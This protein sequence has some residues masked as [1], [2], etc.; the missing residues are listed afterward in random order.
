VRK[1][2][3]SKK[4]RTLTKEQA[5]YYIISNTYIAGT[6]SV[7]SDHGLGLSPVMSG[8]AVGLRVHPDQCLIINV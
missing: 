1:K 7:I 2:S 4:I 6:L 3:N 5:F 8:L